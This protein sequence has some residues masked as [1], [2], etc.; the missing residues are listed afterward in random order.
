[1]DVVKK[2]SDTIAKIVRENTDTA[3]DKE[4]ILSE[5]IDDELLRKDLTFNQ[6]LKIIRRVT[7]LVENQEP[8]TKEERLK[9]VWEHKNRFSIR[10]INLETGKAEISWKKDELERYCTMY[11]VTIDEFVYWKLGI[12][13]VD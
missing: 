1:M 10:T 2:R 6:K 3:R 8:R 9:S 13:L 7:E 12:D 4:D 11:G 5:M